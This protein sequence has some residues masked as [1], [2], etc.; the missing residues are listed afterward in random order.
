MAK[1]QRGPE[2]GKKSSIKLIIV[3]GV[4]V[5]GLAAGV[6]A[7]VYFYMSKFSNDVENSAPLDGKQMREPEPV[8]LFYYDLSKP[9]IV[10]FPK[11]AS[12]RLI[13]VSLAFQVE[14]QDALEAL[15]KHD[16]MIRNNLLMLINST[17]PDNLYTR[18]GKQQLRAD[19]VEA[20]GSALQK[21]T[22]KNPVKQVFFTAFVMQ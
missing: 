4:A 9:L 12:A 15:K 2:T 18:E 19:M 17:G 16:P 22:G 14:G 10:D 21:M 13:Q 11:G 6:G 5:L 3:I 20:V 7:G 8:D 1:T